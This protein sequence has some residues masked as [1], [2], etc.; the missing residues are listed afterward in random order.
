MS[1]CM[2]STEDRLMERRSRAMHILQF[3]DNELPFEE[4]LMIQEVF[5]RD[6]VST[7]IYV[8]NTDPIMRRAFILN[9]ARRLGSGVL[10]SS[11]SS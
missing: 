3:E 11:H 2:S 6:H 10:P 7:D 4:R 1:E 9:A 5:A 8:Q